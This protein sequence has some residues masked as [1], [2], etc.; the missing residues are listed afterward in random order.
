MFKYFK[1]NDEN[2]STKKAKNIILRIFLKNILKKLLTVPKS[3]TFNQKL[4]IFFDEEEFFSFPEVNRDLPWIY[5]MQNTITF[6][7]EYNISEVNADNNS[8]N[9]IKGVIILFSSF[10]K[11]FDIHNNFN[12][13]SINYY[14]YCISTTINIYI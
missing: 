11:I 1:Q 5:M 9:R 7:C 13:I 3:I 6:P 10:K 2:S 4:N 14:L 12:Y 8:H